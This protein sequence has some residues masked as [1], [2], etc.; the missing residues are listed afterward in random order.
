MQSSSWFLETQVQKHHIYDIT[1][2]IEG[3]GLIEKIHKNKIRPN[4]CLSFLLVF[5]V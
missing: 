5:M 1:N 3:I 2:V 4:R